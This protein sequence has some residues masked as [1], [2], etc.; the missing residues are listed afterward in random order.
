MHAGCVLLS[1]FTRLGHERQDPLS[2][3]EGMHVGGN[4]VRT[5]LNSK[6]KIPS[7]RGSEKVWTC[8]TTSPGQPAQ[9]T[10]DWAIPVPKA[11]FDTLVS[12]LSRQTLY[13]LSHLGGFGFNSKLPTETIP[14]FQLQSCKGWA[15]IHWFLFLKYR[16][17]PTRMVDLKHDI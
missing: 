5:H 11:G 9:H 17:F 2:L 8:D 12:L 14:K 3:C 1:A 13:P 16:G 6:G 7:T 15:V 4:G 10:T